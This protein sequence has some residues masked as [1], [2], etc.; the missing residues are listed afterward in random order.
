M[1]IGYTYLV[2]NDTAQIRRC[3]PVLKEAYECRRAKGENVCSDN[4]KSNTLWIAE[5]HLALRD[6]DQASTW[7]GKVLACEPGHD[8]ARQIKEQAESEY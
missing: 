3:I 4:F 5:A 7:A 1:Y 8:R 2:T 6:L